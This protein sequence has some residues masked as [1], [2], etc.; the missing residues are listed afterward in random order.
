MNKERIWVCVALKWENSLLST[1]ISFMGK[2][3]YKISNWHQYNEGLKQRGAIRVWINKA[4]LKAWRYYGEKQRGGQRVYSDFAIEVCLT[5]RKVYHLGY[6]QT[7]GFMESFFQCLSLALPVPHYSVICRRSARLGIVLSAKGGKVLTDIVVDATGLKVYGEGEWKVRQHGWGKHRTWHKLHV[8]LNAA[9]QRVEAVELTTNAVDD[10][11]AAETLV[12]QI[13]TVIHSFTGDG[14]YDKTKL[15]KCLHQRACAQGED[16]LQ[17]IPPRQG[18]V[19]DTKDREYLQQRN[20]DIKA[21]RRLGRKQWKV[22]TNYHQRSKAETFMFRYKVIM[23]GRLQARNTAQQQTEVKVSCKIL[24]RMLYLA[25][26]K[27]EKV[28]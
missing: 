13:S 14:A 9:D 28:A 10:A 7:Q 6:R 15:R 22:L 19:L 1:S 3:K 20:E 23:G 27:S 21:M 2:G 17:C 11:G 5:V 4:V 24:N 16:I 8:A 12:E 25:K 18:A 26:P